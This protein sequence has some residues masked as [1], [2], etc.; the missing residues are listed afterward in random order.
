MSAAPSPL[1]ALVARTMRS[2]YERGLTTL[3]GGNISALSPEGDIWITPGGVDKGSLGPEDIVRAGREGNADGT[4]RPS[5]ELPFHRAAYLSRPGIGAL[6]HAHPPA[7]VAFSAA[8]RLPDPD[9][10][11]SL[12]PA[13]GRLGIADY[14][15]PGSD[16]LGEAVAA[17]LAEGC[18]AVI[19]ENHGVVVAGACLSEAFRRF[20]ALNALARMEIAARRLGVPRKTAPSRSGGGRRAAPGVPAP[21]SASSMA[22]RAIA[23]RARARGLC[24]MINDTFSVRSGPASFLFTEPGPDEGG[25]SSDCSAIARFD[26]SEN[27]ACADPVIALHAAVYASHPKIGALILA[28]PEHAMAFAIARETIDSRILPESYILLRSPP[29]IPY[30]TDAPSVS[31]ALSPSTPLLILENEGVLASGRDPLEAFDR[32]EVAEFSARAIIEARAAGPIVPIEEKGIEDII[33]AFK[34]EG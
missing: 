17:R 23:D 28:R 10:L 20:V 25:D 34:L 24:P 2:V 31:A 22:L 8:R 14:A 32:L 1:A 33:E 12:G 13:C 6:L 30:G 16:A 21:D 18:D 3:S 19:L 7:L 29:L 11:P 9:F 4:R 5:S 15:L 26:C 27:S